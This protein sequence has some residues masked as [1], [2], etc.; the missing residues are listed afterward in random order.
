MKGRKQQK[1]KKKKKL[2]KKIKK[3]KKVYKN[4][5]IPLTNQRTIKVP[6]GAEK[7]KGTE[8]SF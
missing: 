2:I 7:E 4:Y 6:E 1:A 3:E 8:N 5:G